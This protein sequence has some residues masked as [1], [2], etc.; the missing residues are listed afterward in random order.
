MK[1]IVRILFMSSLLF[2]AGYGF[3]Q[4]RMAKCKIAAVARYTS[5]AIE[6]RWIPDNKTILHL[7]FA[8][9]FTIERSDSGSHLFQKISTVKAFSRTSWDTLILNEK[10]AETKSNLELAMD[11]LF[12]G[13]KTE[14]KGLNLDDGIAG[15]N[16][17]KAKEDMVYAIFVLTAIKDTKIAEALGLGFIDKTVKK[18]GTYT[19]RII[20]D[21]ASSVYQVE[22]GEVSLKAM[23]NPEKYRNEVFVYPGDKKLSFVWSAKRELAGFFVERAAEG[24][25]VFKPLNTTPVYTSGSPG[26]EGTMNGSYLDDSLVNYRWYRYRFYGITAFGEKLLF[27]EVKGMPRD[28]TPPNNPI[29]KQPKQVTPKEVLV[30]WDIYGDISD[31]KGFIVARS[32]KDTGNFQILHRTLLS[33][34]TRS[35]TDTGFHPEEP[36]YYIVYAIDTAGNMSAS[37]PAYVALVDSTAPAKPVIVSAIIDSAGIVTLT[38]KQG[39]EKDLKGYRVFKSNSEEHEFS[40]I[41]EFFKENKNDTNRVK[42]VFTDTVTLNSLTPKIYYRVKALDF[43]YNQSVFSA[44]MA[45]TKPD[46]IS[47]VPPVFTGVIVKENQVALYFAPSE[48]KDVKEQVIYR[49]TD[50]AADWKKLVSIPPI[51]DQAID[52]NVRAGTTYYYTIR[53]M[54]AGNLYSNYANPVYGKPFD[55]GIRPPVTN[56][57]ASLQNKKV[58]LTWNYPVLKKEVFFVIYKKNQAGELVQ[59]AR[60]TEKE[61]I[62]KNTGRENVYAIR[63]LTADG[64]QSLLSAFVIQKAE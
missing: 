49:K 63:A 37:Y 5:G 60:L 40:V 1:N 12:P 61:F 9:S 59:Y 57:A 53:A 34:T 6:L 50:M 17:Q 23:L 24:E 27:A 10:N 29:I 31:L 11:F 54:D 21:A 46:T 58:V 51:Q 22:Q 56:F 62:D 20:L 28:L 4:P 25:G 38:V 15:L 39:Q 36:N 19:Y 32:D 18:G 44:I 52:T 35:Y 26:F 41:G 2:S 43:N 47:P 55:S 16:E 45:V 13:K 14:Q 48:S 8:N 64:G 33:N 42:T 30:G 7:G 3:C